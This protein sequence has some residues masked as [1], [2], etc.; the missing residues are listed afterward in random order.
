MMRKADLPMQESR[1][2]FQVKR[3][4]HVQGHPCD[5]KGPMLCI[6]VTR[7]LLVER[8]RSIFPRTRLTMSAKR[9][10]AAVGTRTGLKL[11]Q[12]PTH[13]GQPPEIALVCS[14]FLARAP[15]VL[16]SRPN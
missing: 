14:F 7:C 11:A 5:P 16:I 13:A 3:E 2:G 12:F 10:S 8:L 1:S 6:Y 4:Y 9:N 15:E